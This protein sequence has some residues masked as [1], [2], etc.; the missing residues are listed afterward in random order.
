MSVLGN[1][2]DQL[3]AAIQQHVGGCR[4]W[5]PEKSDSCWEPAEFVL[6][7]KLIPTEGLGPRCYEHAK[8]YIDYYGLRSRSQYALINIRDL[9]FDLQHIETNDL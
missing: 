2:N 5:C 8:K 7:G 1:D 3:V 9:A 6:W 4:E